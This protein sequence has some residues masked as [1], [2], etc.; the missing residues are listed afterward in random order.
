MPKQT[1]YVTLTI[2]EE[3]GIIS[4]RCVRHRAPGVLKFETAWP[5]SMTIFDDNGTTSLH[6]DDGREIMTYG[7]RDQAIGEA[8]TSLRDN[9]D[10]DD[11]Y[12]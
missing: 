3:Y 6:P 1:Y 7:D 12:R 10:R 9:F 8:I 2:D 5:T 4:A 11:K